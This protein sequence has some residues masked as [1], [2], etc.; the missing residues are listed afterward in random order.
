MITPTVAVVSAVNMSPADGV[1]ALVT[2]AGQP[3]GT[4]VLFASETA[5]PTNETPPHTQCVFAPTAITGQYLAR[6]PRPGPWY[7]FAVDSAQFLIVPPAP[8]VAC[9]VGLVDDVDLNLA[10]LYIEGILAAH[11]PALESSLASG[12]SA[13][14]NVTP[15]IKH[16]CYGTASGIK[17]FPAILITKPRETANYVAM[18]Y[19]REHRY[20]LEIFTM[21]VHNEGYSHLPL[22]VKLAGRVMEILNQPGN[23]EILL[24]S[25]TRLAFC[26]CE[27]GESDDSQIDDNMWGAV[28]SVV[29]SG[30]TLKQNTIGV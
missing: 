27:Q 25:G 6:V 1:H 15:T 29:W 28:G 24:P 12:W 10:G 9:F 20:T 13:E 14:T 21:L 3:T 26:Q 23:D 5:V 4:L 8:P 11:R 30:T 16:I 22:A 18:P 7:F 17:G 2:V 19:I